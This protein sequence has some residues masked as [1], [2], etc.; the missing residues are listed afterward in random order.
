[1]KRVIKKLLPN[2]NLL[3]FLPAYLVFVWMMATKP[4]G[5]SFLKLHQAHQQV[6]V[7]REGALSVIK[8]VIHYFHAPATNRSKTPGKVK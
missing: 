7:R 1:M 5:N 2:L 6:T 8:R 4:E 3:V